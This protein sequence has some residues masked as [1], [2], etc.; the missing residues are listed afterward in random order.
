MNGQRATS[1]ALS[2]WITENPVDSE[3]QLAIEGGAG[4]RTLSIRSA[5]LPRFLVQPGPK[6]YINSLIAQLE[7][8][9][10][11]LSARPGHESNIVLLNQALAYIAFEDWRNAI[12][13]LNRFV[14]DAPN[15]S[16]LRPAVYYYRGFC[17]ERIDNPDRAREWYGKASREKD[18]LL[19]SDLAFDFQTLGSW[20]I[21]Y[22][23]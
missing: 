16:I 21:D 19:Q 9:K 1:P 15:A 22:L 14:E 20:R 17:F 18:T 8:Q 4:R 3:L 23:K 12:E 10:F 11:L 6:S 5:P 13:V 2:K 7:W